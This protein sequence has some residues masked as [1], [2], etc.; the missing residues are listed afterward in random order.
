MR[1]STDSRRKPLN[2]KLGP[3][4]CHHPSILT[5]MCP[6]R[7]QTTSLSC[8]R[9]TAQEAA[10]RW[11]PGRDARRCSILAG[12]ATPSGANA[13]LFRELKP[14][15]ARRKISDK[16]RTTRHR[17]YRPSHR[18]VRVSN[19]ARQTRSSDGCLA[20]QCQRPDHHPERR[21][22]N[23]FPCGRPLASKARS[24]T[25]EKVE[26]VVSTFGPN[27]PTTNQNSILQVDP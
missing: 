1:D 2:L 13:C 25:Q 23:P 4:A 24:E 8:F 10:I 22:A 26:V 19:V 18:Q 20:C 11:L 21:F 5:H 3:A 27:K 6:M 12:M 7:A 15:G 17:G 16:K 9:L 14:L